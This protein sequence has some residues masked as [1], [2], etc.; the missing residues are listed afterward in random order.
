MQST[1]P[2]PNHDTTPPP[3]SA[4]PVSSV[5]ARAALDN[6]VSFEDV[7]A[8]LQSGRSQKEITL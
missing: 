2:A 3:S 1:T 6:G 4:S 8:Y 7:A 5:L